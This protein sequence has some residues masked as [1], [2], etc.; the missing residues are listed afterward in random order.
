MKGEVAEESF[1]VQGVDVGKEGEDAG[2]HGCYSGGG[3]A[4]AEDLAVAAIDPCRRGFA[5]TDGELNEATLGELEGFA[6]VGIRANGDDGGEVGGPFGGVESGV[7]SGGDD[8]EFS[9]IEGIEPPF[10]DG[11][12]LGACRGAKAALDDVVSSEGGGT[13]TFPDDGGAGFLE[14]PEH[15]EGADFCLRR[16][17]VDDGCHSSA[18]PKDI[19]ALSVDGFDFPAS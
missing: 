12:I 14:M 1:G 3:E 7:A 4:A 8:V 19:G 6:V 16:E 17:S 10:V 9:Q 18:V 5:S 13:H 11:G 15:T 2:E